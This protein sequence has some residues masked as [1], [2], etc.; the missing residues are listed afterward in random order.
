[1]N[2]D[3]GHRLGS[4]LALLWL[5]CRPAAAAP[6]R[7]VVWEPPYAAGVALK[8]KT[9]KQKLRSFDI[10][11][12]GGPDIFSTISLFQVT[13]HL[14]NVESLGKRLIPVNLFLGQGSAVR[15]GKIPFHLAKQE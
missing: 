2:S 1:M 10:S 6:I 7:L 8:S 4:D 5:W 15:T 11:K 13:Q 14:R 12:P 3:A 9:K